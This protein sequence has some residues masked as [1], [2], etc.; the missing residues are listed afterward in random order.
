[1]LFLIKANFK[2]CGNAHIT[3]KPLFLAIS[4][5]DK[6]ITILYESVELFWPKHYGQLVIL[7]DNESSADHMFGDLI[8][9]VPCLLSE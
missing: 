4:G 2:G 7:L 5:A 3:S 9:Q 6:L 8:S 1:M